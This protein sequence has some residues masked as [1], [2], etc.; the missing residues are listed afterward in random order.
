MGK[1]LTRIKEEKAQ[2]KRLRIPETG[3]EIVLHGAGFR[4]MEGSIRWERQFAAG[5][6][7][8]KA[9]FEDCRFPQL[10]V[11]QEYGGCRVDGCKRPVPPD[12]TA[13]GLLDWI[14]TVLEPWL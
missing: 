1:F 9:C 12:T 13:A 2:E 8:V 14:D 5:I 4:C 7:V 6:Y 3:T 11:T 10:A